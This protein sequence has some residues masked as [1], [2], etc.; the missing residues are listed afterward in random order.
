VALIIAASVLSSAVTVLFIWMIAR[1]ALE[2]KLAAAGDDLATRVRD[3]IEAGAESV[4][5]KLRDAVRS[6]LDESV[7]SALPTVRDQVS[8][9]VRDGAEG[10]VPKVRDEVRQGVEEAIANA[11]TGGVVGKA[12]EELAR[13]GGSILNRILGGADER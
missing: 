9:G 11:V 8:A 6:G 12:G 3:A 7:A 2:Q 5:P 4:I 13:K 1:K 10:V